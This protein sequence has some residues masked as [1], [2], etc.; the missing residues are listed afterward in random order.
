M[1]HFSNTMKVIAEIGCNHCGDLQ[2]AIKMIKVA[3][4]AGAYAA[5]F[6]KRNPATLLSK[7][8][9]D[10]PHPVPQNSYG[11]TY[12]SHREALE[13]TVEQHR[14]L[15]EACEANNIVYSTSVWDVESARGIVKLK[16]EFIKVGS[17][18]NLN[19][20]MQTI[21]RDDYTGQV[22][23]SLGMTSND[24]TDRIMKFWE[25]HEARIVIYV[26]TSGYPIAFDDVHLLHMNT[27]RARYPGVE[28]G[29]S[30]HHLGIAVDI[31]AQA[32]GA[33]WL[34][35][36]FTLDRTWKGTDHAASLETSGLEMLCRDV[37]AVESALTYRPDSSALPVE[38]PQRKKLK[39]EP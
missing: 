33:T 30:G 1:C 17:P 32:L 3:S 8:Q 39:W 38:V 29:Y 34:E 26:C 22:H 37:A 7:E 35:R 9:Y 11:E 21:L 16:P 31:A 2:T 28:I 10:S 15:K 25:G 24:E 23:I 20:D 14:I 12:G 4:N 36:H 18:S 19:F 6:Q 5:K 27:L 13:F